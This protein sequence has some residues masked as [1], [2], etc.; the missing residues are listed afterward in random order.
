MD[1]KAESPATH[2]TPKRTTRNVITATRFWAQTPDDITRLLL[3]LNRASEYSHMI[4]VAINTGADRA[5]TPRLLSNLQIASKATLIPV[6]PWGGVTHALNLLVHHC[7]THHP[8]ARR[9]LFQSP[10]AAASQPQVAQ[11]LQIF[12]KGTGDILV[13][14]HALPSHPMHDARAGVSKAPLAHAAPW[15]TFAMWD[16][17]LLGRVGFPATADRVCPPGMEE[18]AAIAVQQRLYGCGSRKAV[19]VCNSTIEWCTEF[20]GERRVAHERK[21][22]SKVARAEAIL[23]AI[24]VDGEDEHVVWLYYGGDLSAGVCE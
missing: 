13:A 9:I 6:S 11:L 7:L 20:R 12:H 8:S 4:L 10:E 5:N 18:V 21:M 22:V 3:F 15:N 24:G 17:A 2:A 14:G 23:R 1:T 16:V 19:L